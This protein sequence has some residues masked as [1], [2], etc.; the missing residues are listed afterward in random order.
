MENRVAVYVAEI[1][2]RFNLDPEGSTPV[3]YEGIGKT[4]ELAVSSAWKVM[5]E[6]N[7]GDGEWMSRVVAVCANHVDFSRRAMTIDCTPLLMRG[8]D[9]FETFWREAEEKFRFYPAAAEFE[10]AVITFAEDGRDELE[11]LLDKWDLRKER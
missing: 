4:K 9:A 5:A 6:K 8:P 10:I 1:S 7:F 2:F 3:K 11:M